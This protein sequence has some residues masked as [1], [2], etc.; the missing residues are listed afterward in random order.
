MN[1]DKSRF[2]FILVFFLLPLIALST[3]GVSSYLWYRALKPAP[4]PP[5]VISILGKNPET[6]SREL[7]EHLAGVLSEFGV[8]E[9]DISRKDA[10]QQKDGVS[11][12]YTV[13]ISEKSSLMLLNLK[14]TVLVKN[15]GGG[16]FRG[17]EGADGKV[18]T[19]TM[20][21]SEQPTDIIILK[22]VTGIGLQKAKIAIII[23]DVGFRSPDSARR[24][25]NLGQV[26]TLSILPF[27]PYTAQDVEIARETGTPYM[28]HMPM[29]PKSS[30]AKPGEGVILDNDDKS[31]V[32]QKLRRAFRS[33]S[34]APGLN[35]HMGSKVTDNIRTMEFIMS[36][37]AE[38]NLFF[39]DSKTSLNTV[40]YAT[41]T[42]MGVK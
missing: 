29:E 4:I 42:R 23:D 5:P 22:K 17:I 9:R 41:S 21:A 16:I 18:L 40:A 13:K 19:L 34:G 36:F 10:D 26:V 33:V 15:L 27:Q 31:V 37:L 7:Y 1:A 35:N 3:L 12:I 20:G 24:F 39:V 38:N 8:E 30:A 11:H 14:I 28:L 25:C 32:L 6:F 2:T